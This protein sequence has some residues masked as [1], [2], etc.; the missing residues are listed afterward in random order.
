MTSEHVVTDV[1]AESMSAAL[2][3]A[4]DTAPG[5]G[6]LRDDEVGM[7]QAEDADERRAAAIAGALLVTP[8]PGPPDDHGSTPA[9]DPPAAPPVPR[10]DGRPLPDAV[11]RWA[12][13]QTGAPLGDVRVHRSAAASR[14]AEAL[15][16]RAFT[17]GRH[18]VLGDSVADPYAGAGLRTL[19]HEIGH[20]VAPP[21][22]G[23][24]GRD[25]SL[26]VQ[27]WKRFIPNNDPVTLVE[28][29]PG[30]MTDLAGIEWSAE[31]MDKVWDADA[32]KAG[33]PSNVLAPYVV[34]IVTEN[35]VV[36]ADPQGGV[37]AVDPMD[38]KKFTTGAVSG[39]ILVDF[40]TGVKFDYG[41][42][43]FP[44]KPD[45]V[46]LQPSGK[47][48]PRK[49]AK[50]GDS[51]LVFQLHDY[52]APPN[53]V[54]ALKALIGKTTGKG[55]GAPASQ[56][57]APDWA[58]NAVDELRKR[59]AK[60]S[61]D[62]TG[63]DPNG[64]G[65]GDSGTGKGAGH[66]KGDGIGDGDQ[67]GSGG[68]AGA[69]AAPVGTTGDKPLQG[70]VTLQAWN[71]KD[72]TPGVAIGQDRA[73]TW[74]KLIDGEDPAVT[75]KRVDDALKQLQDSRDP[76]SSNRVANGATT[77]GVVV[78]P[79]Q[80]T[81][82]ATS[83]QEA[84]TQARSTAGAATPGQRIPGARGGAN[85]TA[86]PS[87]ML[88][89]GK[90]P[91]PKVPAMTVAGA[92]ND[93][94]MDLDY[95][96][97]SMGMQDE[98]WNR[99]QTISYYW[100]IIDVTKL[101]KDKAD[102]AKKKPA[103]DAQMTQQ[104]ADEHRTDQIGKGKQETGGSGF[105]S[106]IHRDMKGI[107]EDQANDLQMMSDENWPW[108]ARAEYLMVIGLSNVVRT[109]GS[110]VGAFV[111]LLTEPL[112]GRKIG[113]SDEGDYLVRCV[114]TPQVS[115]E[116]RADPAHHTIRASSVA[117]LPIRV[118]AIHTRAQNAVGREQA[119]LDAKQAALDKALQTPGASKDRIAV[120]RGDLKAAQDASHR[121]GFASYQNQVEQTR[122]AL[123]VAHRLQADL[124]TKLQ[125]E[126]DDDEI[127]LKL[128]LLVTKV[129]L[130]DHIKQLE[131][132]LKALTDDSHES[133]AMGEAA[134]I[135]PMNGITE[136]RP[137]LV[138]ASEE[139]GQVTELTC[140]LGQ[141]SEPGAT[142]TVWHL[143][144]ITS[145]STRK[146]YAGTSKLTGTDGQQAAIRDALRNFAENGDYGRGT[147][148]IRLPAEL[149]TYIGAVISYPTEMRSAP[150][151]GGRFLQRLKDIG[152]VAA[153]AGLFLT[154]GAAVAVGA[155][156][157]IAGAVVAVDSLVNRTQTGH[158]W[159]IGTIFDVLAVL[160][161]VASVAGV[162]TFLGRAQLEARM[163][164]GGGPPSW[165]K[166]LEG[167]E[168]VLH[169]H[170]QFGIAQQIVTIPIEMV[171]EWQATENLPQAQK[172]SRRLRAL[173]HAVESGLMTV[174]MLNGPIGQEGEEGGPAK[175]CSEE[176]NKA[177]DQAGPVSKLPTEVPAAGSGE[178]GAGTPKENG[179]HAP[180]SASPPPT[181]SREELVQEAHDRA[182]KVAANAD[183]AAVQET[184]GEEV[185][186][187]ENRPA[188]TTAPAAPAAKIEVTPEHAAARAEA[189]E[190]LAKRVGTDRQVTVAPDPT[191][192][193]PGS[194]GPRLRTAG[195]A[196]ATYDRAVASSG[197]REVGL[198]F[199]P[200]TGEF[201]VE[202]GTPHEVNPPGGDW[203]A[204]VHL[205][206]N[207]ENVI[208]YRM[209]APQDIA[210]S[211]KAAQ[212][213]GPH[214][215]L[216]QSLLPDG[217][218]GMTKVTVTGEPPKIVVEMPPSGGQPG[219]RIE[220]GSV[221]EYAKEYGAE[222]T[223]VDPSSEAGAWLRK[224]IDDFYAGREAEGQSQG[225][226]AATPQ[227]RAERRIDA[228]RKKVAAAKEKAETP[229]AKK[230]ADD[231][232]Q[233][234][235]TLRT[236]AATRDV[237]GDLDGLEKGV[238]GEQ[239]AK[240]GPDDRPEPVPTPHDTTAHPD[241]DAVPVTADRKKTL[242]RIG[243]MKAKIKKAEADLDKTS[244]DADG[245]EAMRKVYAKDLEDLESLKTASADR[246]VAGELDD[247]DANLTSA[248][249][250]ATPVDATEAT[251]RAATIRKNAQK[252]RDE[253]AADATTARTKATELRTAAKAAADAEAVE[254]GQ[255]A[256]TKPEEQQAQ[257][258]RRAELALARKKAEGAA[259]RAERAAA[260]AEAKAEQVSTRSDDLEAIAGK[261]DD[262][263]TR[264]RT[265]KKFS[266]RADYESLQRDAKTIG[267]QDGEVV[268]D[269]NAGTMRADVTAW[270]QKRSGALLKTELGP[271]LLERVLGFV[272]T[273][274]TLT[275][276]QSPRSSGEGSTPTATMQK[277]CKDN[278]A[279]HR[280]DDI[281]GY[282]AAFDEALVRGQAQGKDWPVDER[283]VSWQV[284]HVGELWLG[285][286]DDPSNFLAVP[287]EVHKA[288]SDLFTDFRQQ[289]RVG[290][291]EG[292]QTDVR[293]TSG[294][295]TP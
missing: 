87:R 154:G 140:M 80:T 83:P 120:L 232:D 234:L 9:A 81:G 44:D 281:P 54:D 116:A 71:S 117:V 284:D 63:T 93:F 229:E 10:G 7:T 91:D 127:Q 217:S 257:Q 181:K 295:I 125:S 1:A 267:R 31:T 47:G 12:E 61:G 169:V 248:T 162:G 141:V 176:A 177:A 15:G 215:E 185:E 272:K 205:H 129:S 175:K 59:R 37:V 293:E 150:G 258:T 153:L 29:I 151:K 27:A 241:A 25:T 287:E 190:M 79:K 98:V 143:V 65:K 24:I 36:T 33:A 97:L 186:P 55:S 43:S 174:A 52:T 268:V 70:P 206:P 22:R 149:T 242:E 201:Q 40:S 278:L 273:A 171:M 238:R 294:A 192:P 235:T 2:G 266:G 138:L 13:S 82:Q 280:Y 112:N 135:K 220:A 95:A 122:K 244:L 159:D 17:A 32:Q 102:E 184:R 161:G 168:K 76:A 90:D 145:A 3:T 18:I 183:R 179:Q 14:A 209:P 6:A 124:P 56:A 130:T 121:S 222:T 270:L 191:P 246:N 146:V 262:I 73:W 119:D 131:E 46:V 64:Q 68:P 142:E 86:Y 212:A 221:E 133:W 167:T 195:D 172:D 240:H 239:D 23:R 224:N 165:L 85:A 231:I 202:I 57:D 264:R 163:A 107:A 152:K 213:T 233:K 197:G 11:R 265:D 50:P 45:G 39:L 20:V 48:Q 250:A 210:M 261:I 75:D 274:D 286:A 218:Y 103:S 290:R 214:T 94:T 74:L 259:D 207:P 128:H 100:E 110:I 247:F 277:A 4:L 230:L 180:T 263:A 275:L 254:L 283:G 178:H 58:R 160:G 92:T 216:V 226:A 245:K 137:R 62:P 189:V 109:L 28:A 276:R 19:A 123:E 253:A 5:T 30:L 114:A 111:D 49:G 41:I 279:A 115:D 223:Y 200:R 285:G 158:L 101:T 292:E 104:E 243:R 194:Y 203:Q 187:D 255:P 269:L 182:R 105:T 157:G 236:E 211:L 69:T 170:A 108:D 118:Q 34:L 53:V 196:V 251:A 288:K 67:P 16:A 106:T 96:A 26:H 260:K 144:D 77:T 8:L 139:T 164:A 132:G 21:A 204:V 72:G 228:L 38:P 208:T 188:A 173:L 219:K 89:T 237:N 51:A 35:V 291:V 113:F 88:L 99:L 199:N 66:G 249:K 60:R 282:R 256:A 193:Q 155:I 166:G 227:K 136:V 271:Q 134:K 84:T 148:A 198:Y 156:G 225:G 78:D 42:G 147:I 252:A 289:F 126:W